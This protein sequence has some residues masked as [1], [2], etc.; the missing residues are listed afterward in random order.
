MAREKFQTLTEQMFYILL[1]LGQERCGAD[2]MAWI[3]ETTQR[4][5]GGGAGDPVQPAGAVPP[6]RVHPGDQGGGPEA[7]LCDH[8][9]RTGGPG[10][11]GPAAADADGGLC[12]AGGAGR[13]R[14]MRN[15]K[16]EFCSYLI[17]DYRG[18]EAHLSQMAARGWRLEK[19]G[20]WFW[21]Y[22]RAEPAQVAYAVTYLPSVSQFSPEPSAD[23]EESGGAVR[24][25]R[26]G[27]GGRVGADA[28]LR[29]RAAGPGAPGDGGVRPAGDHPPV[30]EEELPALD[31]GGPGTGP[32][33]GRGSRS[34]RC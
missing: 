7:E 9:H 18:V 15:T 16:R 6:G 4:P 12:A 20:P 13:R 26:L 23:R 21:T 2:V 22:R 14:L 31:C 11:G 5:G 17:F 28:G 8:V 30:H 3:S 24:C 1:C 27:A 32:G 33:D 19:I 34:R 29:Q 10:G 25:R